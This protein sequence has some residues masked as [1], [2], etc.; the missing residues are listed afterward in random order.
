MSGGC[1]RGD[2]LPIGQ[3]FESLS[4]YASSFCI[5][6]KSGA[7][8]VFRAANFPLRLELRLS[9]FHEAKL[10]AINS[11]VHYSLRKDRDS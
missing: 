2:G 9:K 11:S 4:F 8:H 1:G 10:S 6:S 7:R 5:F 3:S